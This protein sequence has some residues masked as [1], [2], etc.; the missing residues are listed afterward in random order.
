MFRDI[1]IEEALPQHT[2]RFNHRPAA[3]AG[4]QGIDLQLAHLIL[5]RNRQFAFF[6]RHLLKEFRYFFRIRPILLDRVRLRYHFVPHQK[7]FGNMDA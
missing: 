6:K 3:G 5:N 2:L 7:R 1:R 4:N